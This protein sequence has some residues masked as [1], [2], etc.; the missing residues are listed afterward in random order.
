MII[1]MSLWSQVTQVSL[2][3]AG[4]GAGSDV[5]PAADVDGGLFSLLAGILVLE[6]GLLELPNTAVPCPLPGPL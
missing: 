1:D 5:L 6:P 2:T 3:P 4:T